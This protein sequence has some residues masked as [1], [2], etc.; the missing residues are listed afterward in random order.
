MQGYNR[1]T[2]KTRGGNITTKFVENAIIHA[3]GNIVAEAIMHSQVSCR[4]NINLIGK[5][6]L[7]VGGVCRAG[8]EISAR[9]IGS[10]MAT[11]TTLEV[12]V[13]PEALKK[14]EQLESDIGVAEDNLDK[15]T[16]S[17][18]LLENLKKA[19]RLDQEKKL[20]CT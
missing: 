19:N 6:G 17:L 20:K 15:I 3:D 14:R 2:I 18:I 8:L 10:S 7:I 16:K 12:G 9:T 4:K 1:E 5:R 13:D 11:S